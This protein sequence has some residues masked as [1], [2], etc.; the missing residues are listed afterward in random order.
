[1]PTV[2]F[3]L[4]Q[5]QIHYYIQLLCTKKTAREKETRELLLQLC[6]SLHNKKDPGAKQAFTDDTKRITV[7]EL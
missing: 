1:M 6:Y 4:L 3:T 5:L 2:T 7:E